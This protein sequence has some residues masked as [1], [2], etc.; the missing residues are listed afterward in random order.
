VGSTGPVATVS[1]SCGT[2]TGSCD[3]K[4]ELTVVETVDDGKVTAIG[5]RARPSRRTIVIGIRSVVL[6]PGQRE[7]LHVSLNGAGR[8]LLTKRHKLR[9]ELVIE[10]GGKVLAARPVSL[11]PEKRRKTRR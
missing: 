4:S 2:G 11:T 7:L 5:A 1:V 10:Q 9:A 8:S 6:R 3:I